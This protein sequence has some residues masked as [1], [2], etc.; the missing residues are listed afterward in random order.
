MLLDAPTPAAALL[1][2]EQ[3]RS[4]DALLWVSLPVVIIFS[5]VGMLTIKW[6]EQTNSTLLL[7]A[8]L[9]LEGCAFLLYPFSM[10]KYHLRTITACW[11]GG[12][13][14]TAVWG[15]SVFFGETPTSTS[16]CGCL[17]VLTGI[18]LNATG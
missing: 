14:M 10:R 16:L 3:G 15:G 7:V 11:A 4:L 2:E 8:G 12:S 5:S 1:S 13:L 17:L 6:S 18:V 9:S